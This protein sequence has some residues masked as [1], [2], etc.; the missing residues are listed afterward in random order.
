MVIVGTNGGGGRNSVYVDIEGQ[1]GATGIRSEVETVESR[2]LSGFTESYLGQVRVAVGMAPELQPPVELPMVN[3]QKTVP[4]SR[5]DP[6][7][8]SEVTRQAGTL[9]TVLVPLHET[10]D[11]AHTALLLRMEASV[12]VQ[13]VE[14]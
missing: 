5:L 7:R 12:G 13:R 3:Q 1:P 14:E 10:A 2:L 4:S 9:E 11:A 6:A 8:S